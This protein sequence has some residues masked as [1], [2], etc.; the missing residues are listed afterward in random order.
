MEMQKIL[1]RARLIT[2]DERETLL[3]ALCADAARETESRLCCT[4]EEKKTHEEALCA[5]AAALAVY[6]LVLLDAA[7]SPDSVTAGNVRAEYRYNTAQAKAY[8][9]ACMRA[10]SEFLRDETFF[11]GGVQA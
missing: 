4:E 10:V 8:M 7:Q 3:M 6:R 2:G 9:E 11:F 1:A 5:L